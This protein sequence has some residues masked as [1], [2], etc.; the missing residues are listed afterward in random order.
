MPSL[1]PRFGCKCILLICSF[2]I[3]A[4]EY[5]GYLGYGQGGLIECSLHT[6]DMVDEMFCDRFII[7]NLF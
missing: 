2:V 1:E 5:E 7:T 6:I 3:L 4:I